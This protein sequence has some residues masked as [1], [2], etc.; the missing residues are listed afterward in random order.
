MRI[1]TCGLI[2]A[3]DK[4]INLGELLRPRAL[5]AVPFGGRYRIIDFALSNMVNSGIRSVGVS[6]FNK[7]E[8][9]MDHL[10]TGSAWDLDRKTQGLSILPPYI[11]SESYAGE[12][13]DL[14]GILNYFR[15]RKEKYLIITSANV[16][17]TTTYNDFIESH[18]ESGA[19]MSVMYNRDGNEAGAPNL[20]L[21][22]D[23]RGL[24]KEAFSNPD[25]PVSVRSS[26]GTV[27]MERELFIDM[28]SYAVSRGVAE[29]SIEYLIREHK[30]MTVRGHEYKGVALRVNS[31]QDYFDATM[32][33]LTED[34]AEALYWTDNPVYTKVKDEAPAFFGETSKVKGS[35]VSDGCSIEGEVNDS[36]LFRGV[37]VGEGTTLDNCIIFQNT[38]IGAGCHLS[39]VIID[40]DCII[41]PGISLVGQPDYP[42]VI[43]KG[44]TV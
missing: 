36:L 2:L 42:V 8:S 9:L 4:R 14:L 23:R 24:V 15:M 38:E 19:D 33:S 27:C 39:H 10:G 44:A 5:A 11:S 37:Q 41:R 29:V 31:I 7:Y 32:R 16:I 3:D 6:T 12:S 35:M 40:K 1:D 25:K 21:D 18:V 30:S 22:L 28:V 17:M 13:D 43:G 20:I 26:L 34:V